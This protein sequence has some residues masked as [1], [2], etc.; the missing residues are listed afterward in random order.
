MSLRAAAAL[1]LAL[2]TV[3]GGAA[4]GEADILFVRATR[5]GEAWRFEV[6][7]RHA[8]TGWEHYADWWRVLAPDGAELGR[9]VLLHPHETE[10]PFTRDEVI[11]IPPGVTTVTV[12]AHDTVHGTGG[13]R[14]TVDMRRAKGAGFEVIR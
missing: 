12:E 14:V 11:R 4:G 10:Q 3:A 8:D 13:K 6:T 9:R 1:G 2:V 7:V 5:E